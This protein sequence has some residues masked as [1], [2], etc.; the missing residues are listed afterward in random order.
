MNSIE[1]ERKRL[2]NERQVKKKR[3]IKY[4]EGESAKKKQMIIDYWELERGKDYFSYSGNWFLLIFVYVP[5][6]QQNAKLSFNLN[7]SSVFLPYFF[8]ALFFRMGII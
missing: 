4:E 5:V 7:L 3:S 6:W 2:N 1:L 8:L